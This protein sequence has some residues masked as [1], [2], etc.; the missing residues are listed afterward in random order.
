MAIRSIKAKLFIA[1]GALVVVISLV[2]MRLS[3]L[4]IT[5][6]EAVTAAVL[7]DDSQQYTITSID[8][9]EDL[10][11]CE[12]E[13]LP[14]DEKIT[15]YRCP[16][17]TIYSYATTDAQGGKA[18][19]LLDATEVLP[20][21]RFNSVVSLFY[22]SLSLAAILL[23]LLATWLIANQLAQP[24]QRLTAMVLRQRTHNDVPLE[25]FSRNDEIGQ[26]ADAFYQTYSELQNALKREQDFT[27]DVSHELRTPITL[28]KNSL[29]LNQEGALQADTM[30]LL[31]HATQELQQTINVLLALARKENLNF[32]DIRFLPL[33]EHTVLGIHRAYP[34]LSFNCYVDI[35][36]QLR[37]HGNEHLISLLC[38]N[39]INNGFYHGDAD[40]MNVYKS[41]D[42]AIV[43]ENSLK[44]APQRPYYQG[45]G[46]GQYLVKRIASVMGWGLVIEQT[47]EIYR[48][49]VS[50]RIVNA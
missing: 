3:Y 30:S 9:A 26:L 13:S 8:T 41:N 7:L 24:I 6:S 33:L 1:F 39:L 16:E 12:S 43:F 44:E 19:R 47:D 25:R 20:F 34:D 31:Q 17:Q 21:S 27:R 29:T 14:H 36:A 37:V 35:P 10:P 15:I 46:H 4:A 22:A 42:D 48:V 49:K 50:P 2:Y 23:A 38:Q 45:L 32:T 28:I 18:W 40:G 11:T 5:T